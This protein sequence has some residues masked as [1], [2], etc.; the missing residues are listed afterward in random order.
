MQRIEAIPIRAVRVRNGA[1]FRL[2]FYRRTSQPPPFPTAVSFLMAAAKKRKN[3]A[4]PATLRQ[5]S[6]P[7]EPTP[8]VAHWQP[9]AMPVVIL[10]LLSAAIGVVYGPGARAPFVH[11]DL[12]SVVANHSIIRLWPLVGAPGPLNPAKDLPTSGR[13]LVNLAM[14]LNYHFGHYNPFG[15]HIF[16]FAVHALSATLVWALVRRVLRLDYFRGAFDLRAGWL[17]FGV[18]LVWALHPLVT[19]SVEYVTH[20]SELMVGLCYLTTTYASLRYFTGAAGT[21]RSAWLAI[22]TL[23]C[24]A[25]MACKESM[26]TAPLIVTLIDRTFIAGSWRRAWQQSWPLYVALASSWL[27]LI[28]LNMGG[29]RSASAGFQ[30]EL[31]AHVWWLTQTEVLVIYVKLAFW[32]APL[33]MHYELPRLETLGAAW[34]W[35][36]P[37]AAAAVATLVLLHRK[38]AMGF[39]SAW[40][41][42]VLSPTL[43]V[44]VTTEVAAE[45]RMYLPLIAIVTFVLVGTYKLVER[46]SRWLIPDAETDAPPRWSTAIVMS[47]ALALAVVCGVASARRVEDYLDPLVLW[48][49]VVD[50]QPD[51]VVALVALAETLNVNGRSDEALDRVR[52][53]LLVAP[54]S[55]VPLHSLGTILLLRGQQPEAIASFEKVVELL[56]NSA[57]AYNNLG[58][59]LNAAG[60]TPEA[61]AVYEKALQFDPDYLEAHNNLATALANAGQIDDALK[62]YEIAV[63]MQPDFVGAHKSMGIILIDTGRQAEGIEHLEI[64]SR[65]QPDLDTY[66][67]LV[68]AY[69]SAQRIGNALA[70]AEEALKLARST[71]QTDTIGKLEALRSQVLALQAQQQQ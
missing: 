34:P 64:A 24:F 29:P 54:D 17:A 47:A 55:T 70:T 68:L 39:L 53:A 65:L 30:S 7:A 42:V 20:R 1:G 19:Q 26:V 15:Y 11:D 5:L 18:A 27:L 37:V 61:I 46:I 43:V 49:G 32:P 23:S 31:P 66:V 57:I 2:G 40:F 4:N 60:K 33:L 36:L 69:T 6:T 62:Q 59:A 56:P 8:P 10:A 44:P 71:G 21:A 9:F 12:V 50:V 13:P 25:G 51:N 3:P 48:Q 14:A 52:Q 16:N 22:A 58:V 41:L 45:R 28:G 38:S 63:R 67:R 35:A